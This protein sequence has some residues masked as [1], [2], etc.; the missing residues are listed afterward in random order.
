MP[1]RKEIKLAD[2]AKAHGLTG[3]EFREAMNNADRM[4]MGIKPTEEE[5]AA[6]RKAYDKAMKKKAK[7]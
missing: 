7:K 3:A 2:V 4:G 5:K 1:K 6:A